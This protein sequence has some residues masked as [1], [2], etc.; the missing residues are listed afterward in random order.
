[1][2]D[3]FVTSLQ[4]IA[5]A[6]RELLGGPLVVVEPWALEPAP[7]L[8]RPGLMAG[9]HGVHF[10]ELVARLRLF[11]GINWKEEGDQDA[12][13]QW[14]QCGVQLLL[15]RCEDLQA[16]LKRSNHAERTDLGVPVDENTFVRVHRIDVRPAQEGDVPAGFAIYGILPGWE[17]TVSVAIT[18]IKPDA[19][20]AVEEIQI[21][22]KPK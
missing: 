12:R 8:A 18:A 3:P 1:M 6:T 9:E 19:I 4:S 22:A 10:V 17:V 5:S 11:V 20:H 16:A 15:L 14:F 7:E 2:T 21:E 13:A